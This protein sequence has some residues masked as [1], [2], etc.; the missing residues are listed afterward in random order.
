M[1]ICMRL[2]T[3]KA[4]PIDPADAERLVDALWGASAT[5][6]AVVAIGRISHRVR[7]GEPDVELS[8][9]EALA[10]RAALSNTEGLTPALAS[11][12]DAVS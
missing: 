6:G 12:R 10:I 4:V 9:D 11:L 8:E 7:C 1:T 3:G 2:P 5:Q